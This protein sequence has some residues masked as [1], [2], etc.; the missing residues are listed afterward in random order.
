MKTPKPKWWLLYAV[1]PLKATLLAVAELLAPSAGWRMFVEGLASM[2]VLCTIAL[3]LGANRV[4]L[5]L[6][7]ESSEAGRALKAWVA[8]A[9][10]A[11]LRRTLDGGEITRSSPMAVFTEPIRQEEV[12]TCSVK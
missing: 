1:L 12:V 9:P 7:G 2:T 5:A 8:Y 6:R 4:A 11:V 3:W 10:P